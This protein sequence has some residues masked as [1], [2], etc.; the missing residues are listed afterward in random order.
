MT[1]RISTLGNV[2]LNSGDYEG[3]W[4]D[5]KRTGRGVLVWAD[6]GRYE[7]DFRDGRGHGRGVKVWANGG[8]YEGEFRDPGTS[9]W[10]L[11][12]P[13]SHW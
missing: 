13:L 2:M 4:K 11:Y 3:D 9:R 7:G 10:P 12:P 1:A 8:R 5:G 6:G